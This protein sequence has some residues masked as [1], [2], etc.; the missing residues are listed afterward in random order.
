MGGGWGC[1]APEPRRPYCLWSASPA[2]SP[3]PPHGW[4]T[5]SPLSSPACLPASA[6]LAR[7]PHSLVT[8]IAFTCCCPCPPLQHYGR[9][10]RRRRSPSVWQLCPTVGACRGVVPPP[11]CAGPPR[12]PASWP[13]GQ[14]ATSALP[15][16]PSFSVS[17]TGRCCVR[18]ATTRCTRCRRRHRGWGG[19]GTAATAVTA[20]VGAAAQG[21]RQTLLRRPPRRLPLRRPPSPPTAPTRARRRPSGRPLP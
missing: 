17:S 12:C 7:R 19:E 10:Y 21:R 11:P 3:G 9:C 20:A 4:W 6:E 13:S 8:C 15:P 16:P 1:C 18:R 5:A 14:C 2:L